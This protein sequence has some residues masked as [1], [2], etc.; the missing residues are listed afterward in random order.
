M[1]TL[2]L[3]RH[4]QS[5]ANAGGISKPERDISLS[6]LG[7]EQ[8]CREAPTFTPQNCA[9]PMKP[10]RPTAARTASRRKPC[11]C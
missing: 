11:S 2:Y 8:D 7:R 4:A 5:E 1:K 3:I 6:P 9:A 10:L